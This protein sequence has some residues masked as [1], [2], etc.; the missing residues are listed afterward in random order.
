[1]C[2]LKTLSYTLQQ[3]MQVCPSSHRITAVI[4]G[5]PDLL[6]I[7]GFQSCCQGWTELIR[8]S[9]CVCIQRP[10]TVH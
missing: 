5:L 9:V 2:D 7:S 4:V 3:P 8:A 6:C 1:M 10:W